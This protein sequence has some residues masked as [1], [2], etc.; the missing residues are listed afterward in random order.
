VIC[1][2]V[3]LLARRLPGCLMLRARRA[4]ARD[5]GFGVLRHENAML[6]RQASGV[7]CLPGDR[8]W[9]AALSAG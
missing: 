7:G 5:A 1:S 8:R 3:C 4:A 6:R 9:L 2:V